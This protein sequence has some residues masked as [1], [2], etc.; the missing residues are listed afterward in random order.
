M[1][2]AINCWTAAVKTISFAV[3]G[4]QGLSSSRERVV[5]LN[6]HSN[7]VFFALILNLPKTGLNTSFIFVL[8][9]FGKQKLDKGH[10]MHIETDKPVAMPEGEMEGAVWHGRR[11]R[12]EEKRRKEVSK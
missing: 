12:Q 11:G 3:E 2:G 8:A 4:L 7:V 10:W 5:E 6:G 9:I 1:G